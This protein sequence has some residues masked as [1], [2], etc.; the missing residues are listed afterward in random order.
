MLAS[1]APKIAEY[2]TLAAI[3]PDWSMHRIT[4]RIDCRRRPKPMRVS[5]TMVW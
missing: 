5:G 3:D 2:T 1:T 4:W